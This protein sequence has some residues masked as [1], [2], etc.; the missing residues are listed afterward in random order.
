MAASESPTVR[1]IVVAPSPLLAAPAAPVSL[2]D[3]A[4]TALVEDL[5]A[6]MTAHRG[7]GLAAPQIGV[8]LRVAVVAVPGHELVLLNPRVVRARGRNRSWEGCL[9]VP[10]RVAEVERADQVE[11]DT[12]RLDGRAV[13]VRAEGLAARAVLHEIDHLDGRLYT[14]LVP[15]DALIDSVANPTPPPSRGK[16]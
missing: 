8:P 13:S 12:L 2:P 4:V 6:T 14:Q 10:D 1:E 11:V 5:R 3:P 7:L 16:R 15:A 9:S